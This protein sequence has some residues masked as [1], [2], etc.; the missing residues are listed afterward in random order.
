MPRP[1][2][3]PTLKRNKK[4]GDIFYIYWTEDGRSRERSTLTRDEEEAEINFA[5]FLQDRNRQDRPK[6]DLCDASIMDVLETYTLAR[7]PKTAA[8]ERIIYCVEALVPFFG[9]LS[10]DDITPERCEAYRRWRG[11]SDGTIR[12]ELGTLQA[13]INY[14]FKNNKL[15]NS[16]HV[17][18]PPSPAPKKRWLRR[19]EAAALLWAAK[20]QK[21]SRHHLPLYI[22][23]GLY[24]G[25][26]KAAILDLRWPQIDFERGTIDLNPPGRKQTNKGRPVIRITRKLRHFLIR[27][28]RGAGETGYVINRK[29]RRVADIKKS[30]ASACDKAG[31]DDVTPHTLRHTCG[32]WMAQGQVPMWQISGWLGHTEK[33]TTELYAHHHPDY[34]KEAAEAMD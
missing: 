12:R 11:V 25:A 8:P 3:T 6:R 2:A 23:L 33:K 16:V 13:A 4:R 10:V 21:Q 14:E 29:G 18:L 26:R 7:V 15:T 31:L 27:A 20:S 30:F 28:K 19:K 17:T 9:N 34:L 22:L 1:R 5:E 32:T 24:T